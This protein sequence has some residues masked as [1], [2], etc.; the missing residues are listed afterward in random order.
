M[1]HR[2][3]CPSGTFSGDGI[4]ASNDVAQAFAVGQLGESHDAKVVSA[5]ECLHVGIAAITVN[6]GLEA[7]PREA[8]HDLGE[9]E[10]S[11]IH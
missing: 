7:S 4:Q 3:E 2:N 6:T 8:I 11:L 5:F 1:K 9:D 10:L